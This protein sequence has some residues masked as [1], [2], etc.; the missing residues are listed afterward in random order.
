MMRE[1][2]ATTAQQKWVKPTHRTGA[3]EVQVAYRDS[4][5]N[6]RTC[7][8][9][10]KLTSLTWPSRNALF[11]QLD[12][13]LTS[14]R[15]LNYVPKDYQTHLDPDLNGEEDFEH[16]GG[17]GGADEDETPRQAALRE[18]VA[19]L[20]APRKLS[21][22]PSSPSRNAT[23]KKSN[24]ARIMLPSEMEVYTS[25]DIV[26]LEDDIEGVTAPVPV[27]SKDND[28][29]D[30]DTHGIEAQKGK[31]K[32]RFIEDDTVFD[33]LSIALEKVAYSPISY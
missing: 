4:W 1:L 28:R 7:T 10:S 16:H 6:F 21:S 15:G 27:A 9:H 18:K 24:E 5:G 11:G 33:Q 30:N 12:K 2:L 23:A 32:E 3:F 20:F 14:C 31:N 17:G 29:D 8:L 26:W 13:F 22:P 19:S 25:M